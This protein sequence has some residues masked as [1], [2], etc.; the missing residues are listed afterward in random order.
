MS[1]IEKEMKI[2]L[3]LDEL[4]KAAGGAG[5]QPDAYQT[6][7]RE[8]VRILNNYLYYLYAKYGCP[9]SGVDYLMTI[10]NAE[11]KARSISTRVRF[12]TC[13]ST[14]H[15]SANPEVHRTNASLS[16]TAMHKES[17]WLFSML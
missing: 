9:D 15:K 3:N 12:A 11:E 16:L 7:L 5:N 1:M 13:P 2:D 6:A 17:A 8:K 10:I 14:F 4:M